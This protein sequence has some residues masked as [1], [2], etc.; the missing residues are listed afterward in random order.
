MNFE[1]R[2]IRRIGDITEILSDFRQ[3]KYEML[4]NFLKELV[5]K[6]F[7]QMGNL[8]LTLQ[9]CG[10]GRGTHNLKYFSEMGWFFLCP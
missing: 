5:F 4:F 9:Q 8:E 10:R 1:R 6:F 7:L 3:I 2:A